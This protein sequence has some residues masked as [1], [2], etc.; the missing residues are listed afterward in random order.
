MID[1][2]P[3]TQQLIEN[4]NPVDWLRERDFDENKKNAYWETMMR[5]FQDS[6]VNHGCYETMVKSGEVYYT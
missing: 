3:D 1:N 2:D 4:F 5:E 6:K